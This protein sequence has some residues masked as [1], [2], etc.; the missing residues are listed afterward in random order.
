LATAPPD[1]VDARRPGSGGVRRAP[2]CAGGGAGLSDQPVSERV[3]RLRLLDWGA[4]L[5][6]A[7]LSGCGLGALA[8]RL[9]RRR[10]GARRGAR[11]AAAGAALGPAA[12]AAGAD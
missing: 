4:E 2:A 10:S 6:L 9:R 8:A 3:H 12:V 11:A 7:G 5:L 1:P